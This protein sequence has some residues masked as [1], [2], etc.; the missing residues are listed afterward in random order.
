MPS[1]QA[2]SSSSATPTPLPA[3]LERFNR[4]LRGY[5][6]EDPVLF[7]QM[8][9]EEAREDLRD[10]GV[11]LNSLDAFKKNILVKTNCNH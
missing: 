10:M 8:T 11:D 1:K 5:L 9:N 2:F 6:Y 3:E 7:E 4:E